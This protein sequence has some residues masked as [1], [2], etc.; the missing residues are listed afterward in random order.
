MNESGSEETERTA[1][2]CSQ[3]LDVFHVLH[4]LESTRT[5]PKHQERDK[6]SREFFIL[7]CYSKSVAAHWNRTRCSLFRPLP[8]TRFF[9]TFFAFLFLINARLLVRSF[10]SLH[11]V[12]AQFCVLSSTCACEKSYA[13][14]A[15]CL[16]RGWEGEEPRQEN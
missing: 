13:P 8:P 7:S 5:V 6:S 10:S 9:P 14:N 16:A 12:S 15:C 2:L 1:P 11:F 3:G 4:V